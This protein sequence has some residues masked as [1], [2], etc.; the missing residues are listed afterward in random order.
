MPLIRGTHSFDDH[1]TQI[2]NEWLRDKNLSL[3]A[4]GLLAQLMSH[5]PGWTVTQERLAKANQIGRDGMR[6]ILNELLE[7]GYLVRSEKRERNDRGQLAGYVYTTSEPTQAEPT[8]AEPTQAETTHKKNNL[9]EEH[10]LE[11]NT[12]ETN[13]HFHELFKEFWK[14]YPRKL[15]K[16]K[17]ERAF[18]SA[19]NR[20]SFEDILAGAIKYAN[21]P[22]R[23]PDFTK[24]PA[25]WLNAD[26]WENEIAPSK[27][28]EAAERAR[29][30]KERELEASRIF[31][32]EQRK[33]AE[34]AK[35]AP[36]CEHGESI[37]RCKICLS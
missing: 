5:S 7:A 19:L 23:N 18:K 15:D 25:T 3:A 4:I 21:D 31:L 34:Q 10:Q 1:F 26:A 16:G 9:L 29:V 13:A 35:P 28:S 11:K 20:T 37:V 17:A 12:K 33:M 24:Y 14:E 32:E 2:P 6:T 27:D 22:N 8:L 30:R 36:K